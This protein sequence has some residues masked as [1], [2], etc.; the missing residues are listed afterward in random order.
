MVISHCDL[1]LFQEKEIISPI[2]HADH[3]LEI[4]GTI[5]IIRHFKLSN[6]NQKQSR[7]WPACLHLT[8]SDTIRK[9]FSP[10]QF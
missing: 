7:I 6:W 9:T 3:R 4:F 10:M 5:Q 1:E 2:V 8:Q